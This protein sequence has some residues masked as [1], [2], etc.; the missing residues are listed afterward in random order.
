MV[1]SRLAIGEGY[2]EAAPK[3][4]YPVKSLTGRCWGAAA[5]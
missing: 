3:A 5:A 1:W 4:T 2:V